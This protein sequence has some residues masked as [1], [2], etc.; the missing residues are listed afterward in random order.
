MEFVCN[1]CR[2]R[3]S[4]TTRKPRC[5]CGGLWKLDFT[6]P[7]FDL[8]KV[9]KQEWSLFRYRAFMA[10]DGDTWRDISLGE[11]RKSTRLNSSHPTTSRMPSSA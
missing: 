10:L 7:Q 3:E 1:K 11:D 6:P 2:K 9:D 8:E 5:D 4:E